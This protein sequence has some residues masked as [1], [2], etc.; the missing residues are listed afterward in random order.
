MKF[1]VK[2]ILS[3]V[4]LISMAVSLSSCALIAQVIESSQ[5]SNNPL[6][7]QLPAFDP[8][9]THQD[10]NNL[11]M[12]DAEY[13]ADIDKFYIHLEASM[14]KRHRSIFV[15]SASH[16]VFADL[17][18]LDKYNLKGCY[19][20]VYSGSN[21]SFYAIYD[22]E[23]YPG[24]NVFHAYETNDKSLLNET[25][26]EIYVLAET[27]IN[28][29]ITEQMSDFDKELVI[30]DY[31]CNALVYQKEGADTADSYN[32]TGA[33]A[34]ITG[35]ANCQGYTDA[36]YMLTKM[37]GLECEKVSG[38]SQGIAH[39][40][41][42]IKIEDKWTYVDVTFDDTAFDKEGL[43]FYAYFNAPKDYMDRSHIFYDY[44][45]LKIAEDYEYFYYSYKGS[46]VFNSLDFNQK[47]Y[48]PLSQ[49]A[50]SIEVFILV[51][52]VQPM[53][54]TLKDLNLP[55]QL[56]YFMINECTLLA[57]NAQR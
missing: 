41:N 28:Q 54:D 24:D 1:G 29:N 16:D 57:I 30:H 6:F 8:Y 15:R 35:F 31:I 18:E 46:A 39:T 2:K 37:A 21:R 52:D 26:Q 49:G 50:A 55:M 19:K 48:V 38:E 12:S 22:I 40:W 7:S 34:L 25:E 10:L 32:I 5:N 36:F 51:Y 11:D 17:S 53:L 43:I 44:Q 47:V 56:N 9:S 45:D 4:L 27:F 33:Y 3:I 13:V 23:Y 42:V 14:E 20:T